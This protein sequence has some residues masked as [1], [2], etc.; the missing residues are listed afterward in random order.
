MSAI[1]PLHL[2][3]DVIERLIPHR[4]PFLMVD[5]VEAYGRAPRP[6]L[7]AARQISANE[8]IFEGHFPG[9]HLWPGVYTIEGMGQSCNLL[10][11]IW[12]FERGFEEHGGDPA[13]VLAALRNLE[14]GY[15]LRPGYRPE[16]SAP[17][18][19]MLARTDLPSRLGMS[20]A[21]DVKLLHPVFA[22]QRLEYQVAQSHV[23][24]NLLRFDVEAQV[25]GRLVAKGVMTGTHGVRFPSPP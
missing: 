17:L 4:R 12:A 20:A 21:V 14:L 19:E 22:G 13:G 6:T 11:I 5:T 9:L 10:Q 2:G 8:P 15:K 7:R 23:F 18:L 1:E 25:E 16:A 24:E 3:P